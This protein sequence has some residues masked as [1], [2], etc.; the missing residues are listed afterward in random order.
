MELFNELPLPKRSAMEAL[1]QNCTEE[2][3]YYMSIIE[4]EAGKTFIRAGEPCSSIF[5][6][7]SGKVTGI[8][9]PM[10][11]Q[12]YPFKDFGPGDFFGEIECFAG[13]EKY[14]VSIIASTN[15]RLLSI[16]VSCYMDWM[17]MDVDA[18]YMRTHEN[19]RRLILQTAEARKYLFMDGKERLMLHLI[20]KY[21]QKLPL[22]PFRD[23]RQTHSQLAEEIGFSVKTL[24][25]S[26]KK[27]EEM[28]ILQ[29]QKG[30]IH[31][32]KEGYLQ[33]KAY[34]EQCINGS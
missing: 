29:L 7:L 6:V 23:F 17:H 2:V 5:I 19:T 25:R 32:E 27:L 16:P 3:K 31:I 34:I 18:L 11:D 24:N 10:H 14:R 13:L 8:E 4:V 22:P 12:A 9:W 21:E 20:R 1:F 33:M 26:I 28:G 30:K 15:C